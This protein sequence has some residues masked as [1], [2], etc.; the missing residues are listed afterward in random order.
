MV[1]RA[2][3]YHVPHST[4]ISGFA[5]TTAGDDR[6]LG[7]LF[8]GDPE[9]P[10]FDPEGYF[11]LVPPRY[12]LSAFDAHPESFAA[13]LAS[14][15]HDPAKDH[16]RFIAPPQ[17]VYIARNVYAPGNQPYAK[18]TDPVLLEEPARFSLRHDGDELHL[19]I[20][21][22]AALAR[23]TVG[24]VRGE[25]LEHVRFAGVDFEENDGTP[26]RIDRDVLGVLRDEVSVAGPLAGLQEGENSVR[27][28]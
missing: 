13:Y 17:P 2:T 22:P 25:D 20:T 4:Q 19:E 1:D 6:F 9:R 12:G 24:V 10:S 16:Q 26:V 8:L 21:V 27:L 14:V 3:P 18:E 7:N 5:V 23:T 11:V 28:W 15:P